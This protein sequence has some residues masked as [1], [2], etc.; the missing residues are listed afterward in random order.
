MES[1]LSSVL[2]SLA[3][4]L[5]VAAVWISQRAR[6]Q[7]ANGKSPAVSESRAADGAFVCSAEAL[8]S[9][10]AELVALERTTQ[11][12]I[13]HSTEAITKTYAETSHAI[14]AAL[15]K[16]TDQVMQDRLESAKREAFMEGRLSA[17][18]KRA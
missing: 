18:E 7:V 11:E 8:R 2:V 4:L 15:E 16:L 14:A 17:I 5:S 10:M 13:A 1:A 6:K 3:S 12:R 9:S